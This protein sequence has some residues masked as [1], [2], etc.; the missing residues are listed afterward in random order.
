[1]PRIT[2]K[3]AGPVH[4]TA[5]IERYRRVCHEIH[6]K[7]VGGARATMDRENADANYR[8]PMWGKKLIKE[9]PGV[10]DTLSRNFA[11]LSLLDPKATH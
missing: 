10:L 3:S 9:I 7:D 2:K 5:L 4:G 11:A 8:C 1:M 6:G